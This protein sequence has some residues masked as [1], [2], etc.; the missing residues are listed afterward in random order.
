M[1]AKLVAWDKLLKSFFRYNVD[2]LTSTTMFTS[3]ESLKKTCSDFRQIVPRLLFMDEVFD[4]QERNQWLRRQIVSVLRQL[5]KA[6]FGK[7]SGKV[8]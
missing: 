8:P 5:V 1:L 4:L 6:M 2:S 3:I 7:F